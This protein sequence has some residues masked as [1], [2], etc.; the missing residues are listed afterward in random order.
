MRRE[1]NKTNVEFTEIELKKL[2]NHVIHYDITDKDTFYKPDIYN[3]IFTKKKK[4]NNG[5]WWAIKKKN[6]EIYYDQKAHIIMRILRTNNNHSNPFVNVT[7]PGFIYLLEYC[8]N[9]KYKELK[10]KENLQKSW[11]NYVCDIHNKVKKIDFINNEKDLDILLDYLKL[12]FSCISSFNDEGDFENY[13]KPILDNLYD[14]YLKNILQ[15]KIQECCDC[16]NKIINEMKKLLLIDKYFNNNTKK[17]NLICTI[18]HTKIII[19]KLKKKLDLSKETAVTLENDN[20]LLQKIID[21]LEII[22]QVVI[23]Q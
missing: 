10:E 8:I 5:A 17:Y 6:K 12:Y 3:E 18:C 14:W 4:Y 19:N 16:L 13:N 20:D 21:S 1:N 22:T 11:E 23:K 2:I 15:D 9:N 7:N